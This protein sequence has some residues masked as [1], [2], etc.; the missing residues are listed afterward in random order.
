MQC[1]RVVVWPLR[2]CC[3]LAKLLVFITLRYL[4]SVELLGATCPLGQTHDT[5]VSRAAGC[6]RMEVLLF[7]GLDFCGDVI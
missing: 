1:G 3:A 6:V 2:A 4:E 5:G 7:P